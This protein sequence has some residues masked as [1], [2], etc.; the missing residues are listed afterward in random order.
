VMNGGSQGTPVALPFTSAK[1]YFVHYTYA[2]DDKDEG[3]HLP[4]Q[5]PVGTGV[6]GPNAYWESVFCPSSSGG[7]PVETAACHGE[8]L[9][10]V[11]GVGQNGSFPYSDH[12]HWDNMG[13][14]VLPAHWSVDATAE[15]L[16]AIIA[17]PTDN[18]FASTN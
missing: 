1:V 8:P 5:A 11:S 16:Q 2:I 10:P 6:L 3:S 4:G 15:S 17:T 13:F 14:E 9:S 7:T 18:G 12:R